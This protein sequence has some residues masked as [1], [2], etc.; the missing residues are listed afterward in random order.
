MSSIMSIA[1]T[2]STTDILAWDVRSW[3]RALAFWEQQTDFTRLERGLELG[4]NRGGLSLWMASKGVN[5]LCTDLEH[6]E[7]NASPLHQRFGFQNRIQYTD[8]D[9]T[10]LSFE[11]EFDVIVFKSMLGA[12]DRKGDGSTQANTLAAMHRALKPGGYLLFAENLVGSPLHRWLR[13]RWVSWGS[14]WRYPQLQEMEKWLQ[15]FDE[16]H[17]HTTGVLATLG[18]SEAQR[19]ALARIDEWICN[20]ICPKSWHY[21]AY[22][23]A[24]KK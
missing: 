14:S 2:P 17:L 10:A 8:L 5:V 20:R 1:A 23:V 11:S 7:Q 9:A 3:N 24:R 16:V 21:I 22:G 18:R 12:L 6:V 4:A 13:K 19:H 15:P